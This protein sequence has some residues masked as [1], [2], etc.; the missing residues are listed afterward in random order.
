MKFRVFILSLIVSSYTAAA[1]QAG[2][3]CSPETDASCKSFN[4]DWTAKRVEQVE[5]VLPEL[6]PNKSKI[7]VPAVVKIVS[8]K[9]LS[10]INGTS[11]KLEWTPSDNA[12]VYHLQVSKDAGFNNRSMY[13]VNNQALTDTSFE[14]NNLEPGTKY[15]WRVAAQNNDLKEAYTKSKF[16]ASSFSTR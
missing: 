6:Q 14:V 4:K 2:P 5:H 7:A 8:P 16:T 10:S 15:F 13:V 1:P 11:V 3:A 12:K 9:F